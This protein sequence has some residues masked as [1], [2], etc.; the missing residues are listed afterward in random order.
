MGL[1]E[2]GGRGRVKLCDVAKGTMFGIAG[3]GTDKLCDATEGTVLFKVGRFGRIKLCVRTEGTNCLSEM[4]KE[5]GEYVLFTKSLLVD[6][7]LL[8][9]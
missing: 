5:F 8:V 7:V 9:A 1:F 2:T 6:E 4:F 3:G